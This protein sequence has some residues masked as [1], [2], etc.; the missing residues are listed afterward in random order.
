MASGSLQPFCN[1]EGFN[2]QADTPEP[3]WARARIGIISNNENDCF[4]PDSRIGVGTAGDA[5]G[6]DTSIS[7]GNSAI[8]STDA[9]GRNT[10]GF[11]YV[12]VR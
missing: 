1:R 5:C 11:G 10:R 8:C 2:V 4:T 12:F 9:G 6:Q 7:V 3:F